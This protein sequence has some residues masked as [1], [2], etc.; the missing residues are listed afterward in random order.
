M[1]PGETSGL[2]TVSFSESRD[3]DTGGKVHEDRRETGAMR[4]EAET[5]TATVGWMRRQQ[6]S[7][8][9]PPEMEQDE[10][11]GFTPRP[12]HQRPVRPVSSVGL[13]E[14]QCAQVCTQV[15]S[16]P[17]VNAYACERVHMMQGRNVG[18]CPVPTAPAA[19]R[20]SRR[21]QVPAQPIPAAAPS[22]WNICMS[23][24]PS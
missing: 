1:R 21:R 8:P 11:L 13:S 6:G 16:V 4:P 9:R 5:P 15:C 18:S 12:W 19:D 7:A 24:A 20:V 23:Q 3:T 10:P 14:E 2:Q 17:C 22:A